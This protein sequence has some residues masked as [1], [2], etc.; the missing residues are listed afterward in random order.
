MYPGGVISRI[1]GPSRRRKWY[2][3]T[4]WEGRGYQKD[5]PTHLNQRA[6]EISRDGKLLS[7]FC[8]GSSP[9]SLSLVWRL[10]SKSKKA[11]LVWRSEDM[12]T[13]FDSI[14]DALANS[15]MLHHPDPNLPLAITT[16]A[17]DVAIGAVIEQRGPHGWEPLAF[18][19][20]KLSDTRQL[21]RLVSLRQRA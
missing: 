9:P 11:K 4:P 1:S 8:Q 13:S 14:K 21:T 20:K 3:S 2:P 10:E 12:Q 19:S 6:Q 15:T 17:S 5:P 7:S 18:W 16:D